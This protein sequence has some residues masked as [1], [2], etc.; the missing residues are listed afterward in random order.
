MRLASV[1]IDLDELH[2]YYAIHG[3]SAPARGLHG[4]YDVAL[5]RALGWAETLGIPLTLF[6]IGVDLERAENAAQLRGARTR[7][8]EI[9]NHSYSHRY[10]LTLRSRCEMEREVA[11]GAAAVE[12]AVG[13][14]P[15]GFRAPGYL[16]NDELIAVLHEAGVAYDSSVF[17]SVPYFAAKALKLLGLR[18]RGRRSRAIRGSSDVL[19]APTRPYRTGMPYWRTG[20]GLLELPVQV[21]PAGRFPY[22]GTSLVLAGAD[23]ARLMTRTLAFEPF[24]NLELH[25]IDFLG[26]DDGLAALGPHQPDARLPLSRKIDALSAALEVLRDEGFGF[27]RLDEAARSVA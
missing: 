23:A 24:V 19:R 20:T 11:D 10:D 27:A 5:P 1:S 7:G 2:H 21:L 13:E 3:L 16:V 14:R 12:R 4:V 8:H 17:P 15:S 9:A 6:A 25:G 22:I 18:L 26:A